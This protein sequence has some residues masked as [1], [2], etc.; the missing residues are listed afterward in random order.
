M[1]PSSRASS[2]AQT[3][4]TLAYA[5]R[6][7]GLRSL[8]LY[9]AHQASVRSGWL[10]L[11]TPIYDWDDR[12]L[13]HWL[14]T[15]V[16]AEPAAYLAYRLE[17]DIPTRFFFDPLTDLSQPLAE[18]LGD[19]RSVLLQEADAILQGRFRLFG[20]PVTA[21]GF[22]P[23][24]RA[25]APLA[26]GESAP[27]V[28]P[29]RHWTQYPPEAFPADV[30]LLWE[31]SRF[32]WVFPLV[33]AYRLTRDERFAR[34][35]LDLIESWRAVNRPNAGPHWFSAQEVALRVLALT[36]AWYGLA[37]YLQAAP[38][39]AATVAHMI[40]VH[41]DRL[42]ATLLYS[43]SLANNHLISEAVGLYTAGFLFPEF[44]AA[45]HW[46]RLGWHWLTSALRS[47]VFRDG[48]QVQHS[49]NYHRLILQAGLWA[50]RLGDLNHHPL[51]QPTRAALERM[52]AFE[53][54]LIDPEAG[55]MPNFGPN[56]GAEIL[57]L[58]A[59]P[60]EDYRPTLQLAAAMF[61]RPR[62]RPGPW[63][64][65]CLWF[66]LPR[67]SERGPFSFSGARPETPQ[68]GL[69]W[70]RRPSSKALLRCARFRSR[71]G[72]S[73]QLH[74]GLWHGTRYVVRD[75]GSYL[76]NAAPPWDNALAWADVHNGPL[77][78]GHELMH[79][80]GRFLWLDWAQGKWLGRWCSA[81][82][83]IE[84]IAA[85]HDGYRRLGLV[86]RRC[87]ACIGDDMWMV[88]DELTGSGHRVGQVCWLLADQH[89]AEL[90]ANSLRLPAEDLTIQVDAPQTWLGAYRAG[91]LLAGQPIDPPSPVWGWYS[92]T[93]ASLE[94]AL[95]L[96]C[97]VEG[98]LP[99]RWVTWF[100]FGSAR[101]SDVEVEWHPA[102]SGP[103]PFLRLEIE[104]DRLEA[105][106]A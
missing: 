22:P 89:E 6:E 9:A 84:A 81:G 53:R 13:G 92:P 78:A 103:P 101:P 65:M 30:K 32:G 2:L 61:D 97:Q 4:H 12:P 42:P 3:V 19:R 23:D 66:G 57:P 40:A 64:E 8:A 39:R 83:R 18:V 82:G 14:R 74:L 85:E 93:Y 88:C 37:P 79:R 51:P 102:G 33:R 31:P 49:I 26:G 56:D 35:C 67:V 1:I 98:S 99:L 46:Q 45:A 7:L 5:G 95:S 52:A 73:D 76:Y 29:N 48:G 10:R 72:H 11:R 59:C 96:V 47:Q 94:P 68:A 100:C 70:I 87:A 25:F 20:G 54:D 60:F 91:A 17:P 62:F 63:D 15:G 50:R 69:Y 41:A 80:A 16:P 77:L 75:A 43:R 27:P 86:A 36:F 24:W 106:T 58:S 104:G 34:G 71:P 55:T 38:A 90:S 21:L 28:E 105:M 44:R